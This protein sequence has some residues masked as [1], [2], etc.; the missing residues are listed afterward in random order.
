MKFF[1]KKQISF[2]APCQE[3]PTPK[4]EKERYLDAATQKS[5][6]TAKNRILIIGLAFLSLLFIIWGRLFYLTVLSY[7]KTPIQT[8]QWDTDEK[9]PRYNIVDRNG[10]VL[11]TTLTSW[12]ISVNPK[13]V[14]NPEEV[15]KKIHEK[16][17][18]L[19]EKELLQ[20]LTSKSNFK[21]IKRGATPKELEAVNWL[22]YHF[23]TYE[24]VNTRAYPQGPLF[25]HILGGVNID[26][27]GI[28]GI[29]KSFD[30]ELKKAQ[31]QLSLDTS[32]QEAVRSNLLKS[33]EK[34][35]AEGAFG[36]VMDIHT[37]EL[38]ASVSL[39]DY[40]PEKPVGKDPSV[41]FNM[42]TLGV[43]EFGSV[44]KLFNTAMALENKIIKETDIIDASAPLKIGRKQIE[45]FRG[46]NRPLSITEVLMHSSN[47]ASAKIALQAGYE[48]QREFLQ[49]FHLFDKL[50]IPLPE[51]GTPIYNTKE[52]WADIESANVAFGYGLATTA[53]H[54]AAGVSALTNGGF[55][56]TP[57]FLKDGN[58]N[59]ATTKVLDKEISEQ[60]R[61]MMWAVLNW[62]IWTKNVAKHYAVGGKTGTANI[63]EQGGYNTDKIRAS[64]VGVFPIDYPKYLVQVTLLNPQRLE[65]TLML[66]NAG[67][68]ARPTGLNIITEIAPYLN[69]APVTD[70][71]PPEYVQ[72]AIETSL[73]KNK[74]KKAQ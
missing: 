14:E 3:I 41:R 59:K 42:P 1:K 26:N 10:V 45:D 24:A 6:R 48:K 23:L 37:G 51:R 20:K 29:E 13:K 73:I 72:Q 7:D 38:L 19:Q 71:Q 69:V 40:D 21:Y 39:P 65:E 8:S 11:A 60:L 31:L 49:R 2:Y 56:N 47:I 18:D 62:D 28:S 50:S 43:Y 52:K 70:Y 36:L 55:Y 9:L 34:F 32:V 46:Q 58:K 27:V 30:N 63:K 35:K 12:D 4:R 74:R 61:H 67:W 68:N 66:N 15:A 44:L 17:P 5:L 16:L 25:S 64:F 54:L 33:I 57:T 53:L 22:G